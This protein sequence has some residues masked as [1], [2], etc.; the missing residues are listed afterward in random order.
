M[1]E[2]LAADPGTWDA[3]LNRDADQ[4]EWLDIMANRLRAQIAHLLDAAGRRQPPN[5]VK[6]N[7]K[8]VIKKE[9]KRRAQAKA[10]A[11][12]DA[13]KTWWTH[14]DDEHCL[15]YRTMGNGDARKKDWAVAMVT[16]P[17][18]DDFMSA[19]FKDNTTMEMADLTRREYEEKKK[20]RQVG[21]TWCGKAGCL[22]MFSSA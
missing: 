15:A 18:P 19:R 11:D 10:T 13:E 6:D 16:P 9:A 3:K 7:F 12:T 5:W 17:A 22:I 20:P 4:E 2:K 1:K 8:E 14:W 21:A